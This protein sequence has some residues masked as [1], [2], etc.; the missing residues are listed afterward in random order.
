[1]EVD[2]QLK[3]KSHQRMQVELIS[4]NVDVMTHDCLSSVAL[5]LHHRGDYSSPVGSSQLQST[6]AIY[7]QWHHKVTVD[8]IDCR[9]SPPF[10]GLYQ[11][12]CCTPSAPRS[13][14]KYGPLITSV[15]SGTRTHDLQHTIC[16]RMAYV[17]MRLPGYIS[18]GRNS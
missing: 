11:G 10:T 2:K 9:Y 6:T 16:H 14:C 8:P 12:L 3:F 13:W 7:V 1:M 17:Y 5:A 18:K 4:N 15:V